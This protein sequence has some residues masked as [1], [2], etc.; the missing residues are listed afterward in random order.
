MLI[1]NLT[2]EEKVSIANQLIITLGMETGGISR[3]AEKMLK[4][5]VKSAVFMNR[6]M[7]Y[8]LQQLSCV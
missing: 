1:K 6:E 4:K 8:I 7:T 3:T 5:F 2:N